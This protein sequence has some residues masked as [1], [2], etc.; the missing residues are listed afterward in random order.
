MPSAGVRD[1][2]WQSALASFYARWQNEPLVVNK[3][4]SLQ[5]EI[6]DE[7]AVER[8]PGLLG[9][10]AFSWS[11]P[12]RVRAMLGTFATMNLPGFHRRDGAGYRCM[13]DE[14]L[15]L[16]RAIRRSPPACCSALGRWRRFD[17][18][19]RQRMRAELERVVA[20]PGCR[21]TRSR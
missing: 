1:R 12:N 16:D 21:A 2:D 8:V 13:A 10:P 14:M 20:T 5:A 7:G 9:H 6:E 3:W 15:D 4:F 18:D 19:R 17:P 11:N